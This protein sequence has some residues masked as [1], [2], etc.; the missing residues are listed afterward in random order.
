MKN[1]HARLY[2]M[3]VLERF[4]KSVLTAL[5]NRELRKYM[6]VECQTDNRKSF[7]YL[8]ALWGKLE[9]RVKQNL[10]P[11]LKRT[12]KHFYGILA[13]WIFKCSLFQIAP[14]LIFRPC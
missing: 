12:R 8:E 13:G 10:K 4:A 9:E 1:D 3:T 14:W 5:S 11:A 7:T 2:C 6:S